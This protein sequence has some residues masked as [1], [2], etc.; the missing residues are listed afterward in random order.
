MLTCKVTELWQS[1]QNDA[2]QRQV[3][4]GDFDF[5]FWF[6]TPRIQVV[7]TQKAVD[8]THGFSLYSANSVDISDRS[9]AMVRESLCS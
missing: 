7:G 5:D 9:Q 2:N 1:V 6:E 3:E 4:G 8:G